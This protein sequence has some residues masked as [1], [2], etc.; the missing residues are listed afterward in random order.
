MAARHDRAAWAYPREEPARGDL[1]FKLPDDQIFAGDTAPDQV[2]ALGTL[3]DARRE[4]KAVHRRYG[5]RVLLSATGQRPAR[6]LFC[7]WHPS[8]GTRLR[9]LGRRDDG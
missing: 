5:S 6:R 2:S 9:R 8:V 4:Y 1:S 3:E 7:R